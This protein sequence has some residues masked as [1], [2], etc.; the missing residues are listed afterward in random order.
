MDPP[1]GLFAPPTRLWFERAFASPTPVQAM[2][3]PV[4]AAG[5]HAL[6]FAPTGSGKTLAAFLAAID[7]LVRS[8]LSGEERPPGVRVLYV[9]PLKALSYDVERNLRAPLTGIGL[10]CES[11]GLPAPAIRTAVR[12][13]DTPPRERDLRRHPPDIL[14]T[15]PESLYLILTSR[16]R[17]ALRSVDVVIVDEIHAVAG[18]KRGAHLALSLERLA[19]IAERDPQRI[20]L[21]ATQRPLDEVA[22]FLGGDRPVEVVDAR[23]EKRLDLEVIVPVPDMT[24]LDEGPHFAE[25]VERGYGV[26]A[27]FSIWPAVYPRLLELVRAH[28]ST[29]IFVNNRRLAERIAARVNDLAGEP[30]LRTHHGSMSHEQRAEVEDL[31]KRGALRGL[32]ATS[33]L[34]LGIDMGAVDLVVLVESP[35]SVASALQRVGRAGHTLDAP[36]VGRIFPK[37]RGDLA[38]CALLVQRMREGAI[39]ALRVPRNPLDVLAQQVVAMTAVEPWHVED[40]YAVVR[41]AYPFADLARPVFE[42]VLAMLAG[43]YPSDEFADLRPRLVWDRATGTV[44]ARPE[45]RTLALVS[46]GTIPDRGLYPVHLG[47]GGPRVGELD[48]EMVSESR[49]GQTFILGASTWRIERITAD[50]VIVSPAPGQPGNVPFWRGDGAGRPAEFGRALGAFLRETDE[51]LRRDRTGTLRRLRESCALDEFAAENLAAYL[52]EQRTAAGAVPNDRLVLI[53]RYLDELGDWRVAI[54][55]PFGAQVH[56]PWALAIEAR[57]AREAG[58]EVQAIWSDDGIALRFAGSGEPPPTETLLPPPE[59]VEALVLERLGQ[60]ALFAARFRENAARALLLPRRGPNRRTPL[61]LQRQR[62]AHLLA[63]AS[64]YP[65]FPIVL[66]TYREC[67]QDVFDLPALR[68]LLA[69]IRSRTVRVCEVETPEP[70]PFARSLAFDY[71]AAY[72]YEGDQPLAERRAHALTL[73][74]TLLRALLGDDDLRGLLPPEAVDEVELELQA[75]AEPFRARSADALHDLLRR[76]GDLTRAEIEARSADPS[77]VPGWLHHLQRQGRALAVRIA[78]EERFIAGEDAGRYRDALG[79]APP[80]SAPE[81]FLAPV[82]DALLQLVRRWAR[83]HGPFEPLQLAQR[84]GIA[85]TRIVEVLEC[86]ARDGILVSG[87]LR[88]AVREYCDAEVLR[89]IRRR[90]VA[91]LRRAVEPVEGSAFARF[92]AG[93]HG[94]DS[95]RQG[96]P[97]A[98]R[99]VLLQLQ[100]VPLPVSALE[101]DIL[102]A[103]LQ[104]YEPRWLDELLA[105]GEFAWVGC[106]ALGTG[107]GRVAFVPRD[108]LAEWSPSGRADPPSPLHVA[109]LGALERRGASFFTDLVR[110]LDA[111]PR[112]LLDALWDL[113][114]AGFVTNDTFG[115]VRALMHPLPRKPVRPGTALLPPEAAGRWSLLPSLAETVEARARRAQA[116]A[117]A[118]LERYGLVAR[119]IA[120]GEGIEGGFAALYP[121]LRAM[122]ERGLVRRGYF[123][124][125]LGGAQF[126]QPGVVDRLRAYRLPP[127]DPRPV[128][129]AALDPANP[130]GSVLPWP[131]TPAGGPPQRAAGAYVVIVGGELACYVDRGAGRRLLPF[132]APDDPR[133]PAVAAALASL[134]ERIP[135]RTVR[136]ERVGTDDVLVSPWRPILERA[137]FVLGYRGLVLHARLPEAAARARR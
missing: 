90:A 110:E 11:L 102:P 122:E 46:G 51:G 98:L 130:Y 12:T 85:E 9:S 123:V 105:G 24:R 84:W 37:H 89:R 19:H 61:W 45:A 95:P 10:A 23:T 17:E 48:E 29:I 76:L 38:E 22:R 104:P 43:A 111:R 133:A 21:S 40:L 71:I 55:T 34:E 100:G 28:R 66:E 5:R 99:E 57:L 18:T 31:L 32:V 54:L 13:G 33:S 69:E 120:L 128:V 116:R 78:G 117:E 107:D 30:L 8:K 67:L 42:A 106:G 80:P 36:S 39:E 114:W 26:E 14:V 72:M 87:T 41:R 118:L 16:Q 94:V 129:L 91:A 109:L 135:R 68:Q 113:V 3:W 103:R 1:L 50:R 88:G 125:G 97:D 27:R 134:A 63:V 52:E 96:S 132:F 70:S 7:R 101:R 73:D 127:D 53:E 131:P 74:R 15:T 64:R 58:F 25:A 112:E 79:V 81:S 108:R 20:G 126:A 56:A 62:A 59:E 2:G 77:A 44:T 93:W 86:L 92:L 124:D 60:S 4:V 6:L 35:K 115:P 137:G 49:P 121:L 75:L 65:D 136:I 47:E 83:T 82:P 119:A